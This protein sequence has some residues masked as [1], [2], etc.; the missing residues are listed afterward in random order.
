MQFNENKFE[1]LRYGNNQDIK[2]STS[3]LGPN[4]RIIEQTQCVEDLAIKMSD[5]VSFTD[6]IETV[7]NKVRVFRKT[8]CKGT[9]GSMR[10]NTGHRQQVKTEWTELH[11]L[12][13]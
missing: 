12:G 5:T 2:D 8:N 10:F 7:C 6:S 11:V 1:L 4:N 9:S 13:C 3:Y